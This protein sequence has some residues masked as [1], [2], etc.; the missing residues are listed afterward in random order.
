MRTS[1][2]KNGIKKAIYHAHTIV[3]RMPR[4][5][6]A[7]T[8]THAKGDQ[9]Y[10]DHLTTLAG[11]EGDKLG[12]LVS[13]YVTS[14]EQQALALLLDKGYVA[15][16]FQRWGGVTMLS[17]FITGQVAVT[18][19]TSIPQEQADLQTMKNA[20]FRQ[21]ALVSETNRVTF[22]LS[23]FPT[24][25]GYQVTRYLIDATH[26]N[27]YATY[28]SSGLS[29]AI[30]GDDLQVLDTQHINSLAQMPAVDLKPYSV[31]LIEI[32]RNR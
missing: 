17:S 23:G 6:V 12:I 27:S 28:V 15:A 25:A 1:Y 11:V 16:D 2:S 9:E 4:N 14:P 32:Q 29:A 13:S 8:A 18:A 20:F 7:S 30:A 26:N 22:A 19:L 10:F 21:R 5:L 31:M 24:S 3:G